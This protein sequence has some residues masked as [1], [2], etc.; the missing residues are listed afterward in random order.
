[1]NC[2]LQ[3][4]RIGD[5]HHFIFISVNY[6]TLTENYN[7]HKPVFRELKKHGL[8]LNSSLNQA[9]RKLEEEDEEEEEDKEEDKEEEEEEDKNKKGI[10]KQPKELVYPFSDKSFHNLWEVWKKYKKQQH[11]FTYKG[12]I[13]EQAALKEVGE[14]ANGNLNLALKLI[15]N[16]IN[17]GW[18]GIFAIQSGK[19]KSSGYT[20]DELLNAVQQQNANP[21]QRSRGGPNP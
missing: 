21:Q 2:Q 1:M 19:Q 9:C 10:K 6:G 16:A 18:K 14:L 17:N 11:N 3:F 5:D 15:Q 20:D 7:P 13:S 12:E 8:E 4:C